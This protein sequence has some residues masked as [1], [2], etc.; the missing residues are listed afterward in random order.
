VPF[1]ALGHAG[2]SLAVLKGPSY[3][4]WVWKEKCQYKWRLWELKMEV[5][6][7]MENCLSIDVEGFVES[8]LE[9][10]HIPNSYVDRAKENYEI[11]K[12]TDAF[13]ELLDE[14]HIHATFFIVG[15]IARE[16]P[17]LVKRAASMGHEIGCHSYE[18]L[19]IFN[20]QRQQF[21]EGLLSAKKCLEDVS[22]SRV[23]GFRAPDF[24]ITES[25]V[26]ALDELSE[27]GFLY[28]SSIYPVRIHDVYGINDAHPGIH[29]LRNGLIE[30]PLSTFN[31]LGMRFPFGG[32]GYFRL[33][34]LG[35]TKHC[36]ASMNKRGCPCML[37][38]HPYEVGPIIPRIREISAYR[39]FR[40]YYN[41]STGRPRL[42]KIIEEFK[43]APAVRILEKNGVADYVR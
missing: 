11:E 38:I 15:R 4:I 22:G 2:S 5:A 32:G 43:F 42:K 24:S 28:D 7:E 10:F 14:M 17:Q 33:Y 8:N 13:I 20:L 25:S 9:S 30:W 35:V 27:A 39:G 3:G 12:N 16:I 34:P 19:R 26:W 37:Y 21:K 41:C 29:K 23:Y 40:H 6:A 36:I 1:L 31:L 18:H